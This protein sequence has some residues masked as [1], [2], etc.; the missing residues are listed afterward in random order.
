M[1]IL[2]VII[3]IPIT[4]FT[5]AFVLCQLWDWFIV[6]F[7]KVQSLT[8]VIAA[9]LSLISFLLCY[10]S[11]DRKNDVRKNDDENSV[12]KILTNLISHGIFSPLIAL[13]FGWIINM[14]Q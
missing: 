4:V 14:F 13:F 1:Q 11:D 8:I 10:Q 7:F 2:L 6:P 3:F 9:S 12:G 5:R